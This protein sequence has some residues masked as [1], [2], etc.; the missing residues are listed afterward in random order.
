[1]PRRHET[2][3]PAEAAPQAL[4]PAPQPVAPAVSNAQ[5]AR[6]SGVERNLALSARGA[7]NQALARSVRLIQR[8]DPPGGTATAAPPGRG[9]CAEFGDYWIVPDST[10]VCYA[11]VVGEQITETEFA[12]LLAVWNKLKDGSGSVKI[13]EKD[14][15]GKDHAGF[16]DKIL[17]L[18]GKLLSLPHGRL[19]VAGLVNGSQTV[20]I[21]PTSSRKIA[22]ATRGAGSLENADGTAGAGGGT[23]I[24]LDADLTDTSVVAFDKDGKEIAAPVW[25][26]LGHELIHAEHNAAGRN[27]RERAATNSAYSNLEEEETIDTGSGITENDLRSD[28]GLPD[29]FGHSGKD[30]RPRP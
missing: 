24:R 11:N 15:K 27:R 17:G 19:L 29:R 7:G 2:E 10:Q 1:M 5:L 8:Q 18:F 6:M 13:T 30:K 25:S 23:T 21:E 9:L 22:N 3:Q 28:A 12:A 4:E 26:I 16:R 14:D 20:T